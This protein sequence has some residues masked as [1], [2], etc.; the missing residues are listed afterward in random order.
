MGLAG[1]LALGGFH[2]F[3]RG[4]VAWMV[5]RASPDVVVRQAPEIP[6]AREYHGHSGLLEALADWPSQWDSFDVLVAEVVEETDFSAILF[7]R[8]HVTSREGLEFDVDAYNAFTYNDEG[9]ALSWD[10]FLTLDQAQT[11]LRELAT[12]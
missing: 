1:E 8:H 5:E 12:R 9:K 4:D 7:T 10:I 11:R 3:Q 2:A 6:D